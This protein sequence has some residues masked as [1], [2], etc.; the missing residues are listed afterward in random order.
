MKINKILEN[1]YFAFQPI[2]NAQSGNTIA[3]EALLRG[4]E[5]LN[6]KDIFS[7]LNEANREEILYEIEIELFKKA[8]KAYKKIDFYNKALLFFNITNESA[9]TVDVNFNDILKI[10]ENTNIPIDNI[11]FD[12]DCSRFKGFNKALN[13]GGIQILKFALNK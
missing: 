6:F 8:L 12:I 10:L 5:N 9:N 11:C 1:V 4:V 7:F 3:V 2:L 13:S